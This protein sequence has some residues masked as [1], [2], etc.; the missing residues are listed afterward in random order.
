ML[1]ANL[2]IL[3]IDL[4]GH[5]LSSM[6]PVGIFHHSTEDIVALR[7]VVK[8]FQWKEKLNLMGHSLGS[9]YSFV[10]SSL[11]PNEVNKYIG[12]DNIKITANDN[13][14]FVRQSG[15]EIDRFLKFMENP[16]YRPEYT[17]DVIVERQKKGSMD[18]MTIE[19]TK[20]L[21][22]RGAYKSAKKEGYFGFRRDIRQMVSV[23]SRLPQEHIREMAS[24]LR[25]E[26]L[27][28]KFKG[29]KYYED[30]RKVDEIVEIIKKNSKYFE[31]HEVEGTH[32]GHLNNPE[33]VAPIVGNFLKTI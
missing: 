22:Q 11:F 26:V 23:H 15:L 1:P 28:I 19:S 32:H 13:D 2:P 3:A 27:Y 31:Y 20:L 33:N 6:Y 29:A 21:L 25:C 16:D 12:F 8:H 30:K 17:W 4:P 5:G 18:S 24:R 10:Y 14:K 7:R 9:I